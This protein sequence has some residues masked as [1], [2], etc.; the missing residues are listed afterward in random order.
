MASVT[1]TLVEFELALRVTGRTVWIRTVLEPTLI[2]SS[3]LL[4]CF[5]V[6]V[7]VYEYRLMFMCR[8]YALAE[9]IYDNCVYLFV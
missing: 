5:C 4:D 1:V 9:S 3:Y 2:D 7:A 8:T 6:L